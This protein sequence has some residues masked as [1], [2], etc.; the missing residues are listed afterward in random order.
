MFNVYN[1]PCFFFACCSLVA[2]TF[3]WWTA[4]DARNKEPRMQY[5]PCSVE[6]GLA[7]IVC[8]SPLSLMRTECNW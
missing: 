5:L 1:Y 8:C 7:L 4:H 3:P 2:V 6:N